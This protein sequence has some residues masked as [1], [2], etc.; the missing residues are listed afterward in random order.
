MIVMVDL[1]SPF[2]G[3][4][5]FFNLLFI[6]VY[7]IFKMIFIVCSGYIRSKNS[8]FRCLRAR[9]NCQNLKIVILT[10]SVAFAVRPIRWPEFRDS[11]MGIAD[12]GSFARSRSRILRLPPVFPPSR[13]RTLCDSS[14]ERSCSGGMKSI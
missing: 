4:D 8:L 10:R 14:A 9:E 13:T 5:S 3:L 12:S 1:K 11:P 6:V 7:L 2:C